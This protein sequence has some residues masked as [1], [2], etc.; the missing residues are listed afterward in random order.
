MDNA[1][2]DGTAFAAVTT[3]LVS[4]VKPFLE[5][6]VPFAAD[7]SRTHD[8]TIRLVALV[9][10]QAL[11]LLAAGATAHLG[12]P[13]GANPAQLLLQALAQT[14]GAHILYDTTKHDDPTPAPT[15]A[16]APAETTIPAPAP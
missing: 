5:A 4:C 9:V 6:Y 7:G 14:A 10:N 3:Y 16:P 15:P 13:A 2:I 1:L 8:A 11:V 12:G